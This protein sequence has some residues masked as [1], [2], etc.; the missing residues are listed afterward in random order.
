MFAHLHKVN[1]GFN[2]LLFVL[3]NFF[4]FQWWKTELENLTDGSSRKELQ[5]LTATDW[6]LAMD[7]SQQIEYWQHK[8]QLQSNQGTCLFFQNLSF[9]IFEFSEKLKF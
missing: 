6:F 3:M 1:T 8:M 7:T 4:L 2:K 9:I 5:A